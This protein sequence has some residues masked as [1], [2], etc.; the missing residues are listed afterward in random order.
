MFPILNIGP[1]AIQTPGLLILIGVYIFVLIGEKQSSRYSIQPND[2]SNLAFLFIIS[3][4][5]IGRLAYLFR[6]ST[7]FIENPVSIISI[8]PNLFDFPSGLILSI[9]TVIIYVQRKKLV[10]LNVLDA[11]TLP[12][13]VFLIF[14]FLAQLA[15]GDLYGKP[16]NLP[17]TIYLWG[18]TRHPL[19]VYYLIGLV[20]IIIYV[21][22]FAIQQ[23][24]PG[25]HF[26][27]TLCLISLLVIFLDFFNGNPKNIM[28]N[29]NIIQLF[30]WMF[31]ILLLLFINKKNSTISP[32]E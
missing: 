32:Q 1:L 22:R 30:A 15:A 12:L 9:L 27:R 14:F 28:G 4:V 21:Y 7:I 23:V 19:Q 17:W 18:T 20:P 11:I 13:L 16:S 3:T 24:R 8:N 5:I 2:F 25:I 26:A 31:M 29:L 10:L 6:F